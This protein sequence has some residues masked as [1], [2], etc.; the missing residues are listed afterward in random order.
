MKGKPTIKKRNNLNTMRIQSNT[1]HI[2][3]ILKRI[4]NASTHST[5]KTLSKC[6]I[7]TCHSTPYRAIPCHIAFHLP[8]PVITC[9]HLHNIIECISLLH[10][11]LFM[12]LQRS[13]HLL[14][15]NASAII[16]MPSI[17][18]AIELAAVAVALPA[19]NNSNTAHIATD[20]R[21][22]SAHV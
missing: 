14:L 22:V 8:F 10:C 7:Y 4:F 13:C 16:V 3:C 6:I 1:I 17:V 21:H 5:P 15:F 11:C 2:K 12:H 19:R 18:D 9:Q 20:F